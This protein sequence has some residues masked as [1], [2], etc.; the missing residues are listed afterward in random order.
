MEKGEGFWKGSEREAWLRLGPSEWT[1]HL[2]LRE[3]VKDHQLFIL[4]VVGAL[5]DPFLC[6]YIQTISFL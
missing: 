1:V 5:P 2:D 4:T 3:H 6:V